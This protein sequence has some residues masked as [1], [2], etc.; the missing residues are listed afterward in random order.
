MPGDKIRERRRAALNLQHKKATPAFV[1]SIPVQRSGMNIE[2][3]YTIQG[4]LDFLRNGENKLRT[5]AFL[6][7]ERGK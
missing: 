1:V 6:R 2:M 3:E 7:G 4:V 5:L